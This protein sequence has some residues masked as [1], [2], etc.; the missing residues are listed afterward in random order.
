MGIFADLAKLR[1]MLPVEQLSKLV[2]PQWQVS[3][4]GWVRIGG[5]FLARI[6]SQDRIG[7][8]EFGEKFP[9]RLSIENVHV[10]MNLD[11]LLETRHGFEVGPPRTYPFRITMYS[12]K[13]DAGDQ[14]IAFVDQV[15]LVRRFQITRPGRSYSD[16]NQWKAAELN[17]GPFSYQDSSEMLLDWADGYGVSQHHGPLMAF[18]KWLTQESTADQWHNV[19]PHWNWDFGIEP[20][21]WIIRQKECDKATAL[22]AFY[23]TRPGEFLDE[24]AKVSPYQI[25]SF[26]LIDEIRRRFLG[27]FYTRSRFAFDGERAFR[28]EAYVD[29]SDDAEAV[30]RAIPP[31]MRAMIPGQALAGSAEIDPWGLPHA[32][33]RVSSIVPPP[34]T[35]EERLEIERVAQ[36]AKTAK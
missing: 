20:L 33:R 8:L 27:G 15:G 31:A 26:D 1:P 16:G 19:V 25:D 4:G 3:A 36:Q 5:C 22:T 21:L 6:D 34:I 35:A 13:T 29:A 23:L 2:G 28:E 12:A 17:I 9:S 18:T 24:R 32:T 10:G 11:D 14:L 7:L 30:D